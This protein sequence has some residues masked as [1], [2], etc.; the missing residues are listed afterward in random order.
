MSCQ[1]AHPASA[2]LACGLWLCGMSAGHGAPPDEPVAHDFFV[3][4]WQMEDGLP[5]NTIN[6]VLQDRNGFIWLATIGGLVRFDGV[7]FKPFT[8]PLIAH[9]AECNIRALVKTADSTLL[10]LPAA[11]G[12]VQW[13][14]GRF[15][16][17]PAG[18][19]LAGQQL[20]ALFVD[21]V[22]AV[23][24]GMEGGLVRRWQNGTITDFG[25]TNGLNSRTGVSFA[26]DGEGR[27]WIGSGQ[28]LECYRDG[29][30][31]PFN[32]GL[33]AQGFPVVASSRSGGIWICKGSRLQKL[34]N[35]QVSTIST[36]VPWTALGGVALEMFEDSEHALW[37]GTRANGLFRFVDGEF[38]HVETSQSQITSITEDGEGDIW[39]GTLGGGIN[40]LRLKVFHLYNTKS[41]LPEDVSD[42]VCADERGDVWLANR[43]GGIVRI[44]DGNVFVPGL[45]GPRRFHAYSVCVDNQGWVWGRSDNG[46]Y[47]FPRDNPDQIQAV[48]NGPP[49]VHVLFK[50][51]AG[52]IWVGSDPDVLGCFRG[53][54]PENYVLEQDFPGQRPRS[55]TEDS[56]GWLWIGTENGQVIRLADGKFTVFTE[57]DGLPNAPVHSLCADAS[58]SVWVGTIGGGLALWR[59]GKFTRIPV[60]AGFW[61]E[62]I[63][64]M[65]EDGLGQLWCGTRGGIFH[66]ATSDLLAFAE[67]KTP[68][69]NAIAFARSEGLA[70]ISCLGSA[71]PMA[72]KSPDGQLWFATQQGVL[73]VNAAALKS[74][75]PPPPVFIDEVYANDRPVEITGLLRL[76]PPCRKVEFR[77]SVPSY[78]APEDVRLRY[79]LDGVD[80]DWIEAANQRSMVYTALRPG[81]YCLHL[82]ARNNNSVW[83]PI[84]ATLPFVAE[85]AWWQSWWFQGVTL[86][87]FLAALVQGIR[88][89]SHRRL[90]LKL[91]RLERQ[92]SL[93]KERT[94]IARDLHDDLGA[95]VTQIGLMLEEMRATPY[96]EEGIRRQSTD[97][98]NRVLNLARDLDAVVWSIN[99]RR[100]SL[101]D[102]FAYLGQFFLESFRRTPIRP[103]LDVMENV[104]DAALAPEVRH[105]LFL[106]VKEAA[107]NVIKHSRATEATLSLKVADDV[108]EIRIEDNGRGYLPEAIAHSNR[109][110]IPNMR[111]RVEQLGGKLQTSSEPG[112]GTS[113]R[114][115]ISS[116]KDSPVRLQP[117]E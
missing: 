34:Q 76:P 62:D 86:S 72:C 43:H 16:L 18:E 115:R 57:K 44:R 101:R 37:I 110:G 35:D 10:M 14:D 97:I 111:A 77:F 46:L 61:H 70:G 4:S 63:A 92:E 105:Q 91:E 12:V 41:G 66:A 6:D 89:W 96:S 21:R 95:T 48:S 58:G 81:K 93:A 112:R 117:T 98:S 83:S 69:V 60:A 68:N 94:R 107:N 54:L 29:K 106:T 19:G 51:R 11:G 71:Q 3:Q 45:P 25:P 103:R 50:S 67:G 52:D 22:G 100:D 80:A 39:V 55:I 82:Q 59:D 31:A 108:L 99:P 116:W 5:S 40:R 26:S 64:E 113:I 90:K 20:Q 74:S 33:D 42:A 79:K 15:S 75:F 1:I 56:R 87:A 2:A 7:T 88:F 65:V 73:S 78:A 17:H 28:S 38:I 24:I 8:S 13:K 27:V 102:L 85:A 30:L 36:N 84:E 32:E 47:R 53:G 9:A 104:P 49:A 23:W 114:I 109:H